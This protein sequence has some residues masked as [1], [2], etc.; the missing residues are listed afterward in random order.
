M[1]VFTSDLIPEVYNNM[2]IFRGGKLIIIGKKSRDLWSDHCFL[3]GRG[4]V[5]KQLIDYWPKGK[6][7]SF[8]SL[9]IPLLKGGDK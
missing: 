4:K 5:F 1:M 8:S 6:T 7:G 2:L 9:S 3:K